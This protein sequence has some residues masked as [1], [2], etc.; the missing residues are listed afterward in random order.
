MN[1]NLKECKSKEE[2]FEQLNK[3]LVEQIKLTRRE[4]ESSE[5]FNKPA[6]AEFQAYQLGTLKALKKVFNLI[7]DQGKYD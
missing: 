2:V 5:S 1:I 4:S 7:P 3:Y 6:W